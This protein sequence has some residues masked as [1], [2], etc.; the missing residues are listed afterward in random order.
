[1]LWRRTD[2]AGSQG[3]WCHGEGSQSG[4]RALE[5]T[6]TNHHQCGSNQLWRW[7][8]MKLKEKKKKEKPSPNTRR[9]C[10]FSPHLP[11]V[12]GADCSFGRM[13]KLTW[14]FR[15]KGQRQTCRWS[16]QLARHETPQHP[17]QTLFSFCFPSLP[18]STDLPLLSERTLTPL[19][20]CAVYAAP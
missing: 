14:L 1:M 19:F 9:P 16:R 17:S 8:K 5:Y 7:R 3:A 15:A 12:S 4:Q 2:S 20:L 10:V 18:L 13:N 11:W 6:L